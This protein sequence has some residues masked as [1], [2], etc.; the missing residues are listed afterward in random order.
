ME[1]RFLGRGAAFNPKEGSNSAYFVVDSQ[2][3]LI[4]CGETT[5]SSLLQEGILDD[6]S[7]INLMITHT[8]SDHIGSIGSLV[9]YSYR[10]KN[11]PLNII[12]SE[13]YK[14][15]EDI[16]G[17]LKLFGCFSLESG[18]VVPFW[19]FVDQKS[20][21]GFSEELRS[22]QFIETNHCQELSSYGLI[23][24][25]SE[26][27]VYYSGDTNET[28]QIEKFL[29]LPSDMI[30][31]MYVDVTTDEYYGKVHILLSKLDEVVPTAQRKKVYCMHFNND[32]CIKEAKS[33]EFNVVKCI[34]D[35]V[36]FK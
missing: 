10:A 21:D 27:I 6:V 28:K 36:K 9:L 29:A 35:T 8:H 23:F 14:N 19:R 13:D 34:D 4:D 31:R 18:E 1:L 17:I 20:F 16:T 22:I 12:I 5:F 25:T 7:S 11:K 2:L 15:V 3:F 24:Q 33:L 30:D 32:D 26:G